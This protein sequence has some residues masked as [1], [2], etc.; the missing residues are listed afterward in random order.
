MADSNNEGERAK[1]RPPARAS[2]QR[3]QRRRPGGDDDGA[4]G[5][6]RRRARLEVPPLFKFVHEQMAEIATRMDRPPACPDV[7]WA[8]AKAVVLHHLGGED[9]VND[10]ETWVLAW[11]A[12][13]RYLLPLPRWRGEG[14]SFDIVNAEP[15]CKPTR[16]LNFLLDIEALHRLHREIIGPKSL[17]PVAHQMQAEAHH[18]NNKILLANRRLVLD[19]RSDTEPMATRRRN[20]AQVYTLAELG[21]EACNADVR[22]H[23][24]GGWNGR[25]CIPLRISSSDPHGEFEL[26]VETGQNDERP[27]IQTIYGALQRGHFRRVAGQPSQGEDRDVAVKSYDKRCF[28]DAYYA[29]ED[30]LKE[31]L[32]LAHLCVPR[33]APLPAGQE[34]GSQRHFPQLLST[35]ENENFIFKVE[36]WTGPTSLFK[37]VHRHKYVFAPQTI[38]LP[39]LSG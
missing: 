16:S 18:N 13:D 32:L 11:V 30:P 12:I 4:G 14:R 1:P 28:H 34:Q 25:R 33:H 36:D 22:V 26:V 27:P 17:D 35:Y 3:G 29:Q 31:I 10:F 8:V 6:S 9:R 24:F 19:E 39:F 37:V 15:H 20:Y 21:C 7:Q 5:A 23:D 2:D 38:N